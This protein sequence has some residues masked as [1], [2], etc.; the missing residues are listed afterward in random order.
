[1]KTTILD[2]LRNAEINLVRHAGNRLA[3]AIGAAQLHNA[4]GLLAKGY[5]LETLVDPLLEEFGGA[6]GAVPPAS[7]Y[8]KA[9]A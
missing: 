2:V 3:Q 5:A 7:G 6:V 8:R 4:I 9:G 1:M